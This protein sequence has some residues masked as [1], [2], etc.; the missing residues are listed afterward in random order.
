MNLNSVLLLSTVYTYFLTFFTK[1]KTNFGSILP[2][3]T[4]NVL[5]SVISTFSVVLKQSQNDI[6]SFASICLLL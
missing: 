5:H 3:Y 6:A 4:Y 1:L 2:Q